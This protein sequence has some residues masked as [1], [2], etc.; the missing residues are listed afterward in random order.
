[1]DEW[2]DYYQI[3]GVN[4]DATAD[5]IKRAYRDKS[6]ILHPDRLNGTPASAKDRAQEELKRVNRAYDILGDPKKRQ[7]YHAKWMR[8]RARPRPTGERG[9][10]SAPSTNKAAAGDVSRVKTVALWHRYWSRA[11]RIRVLPRILLILGIAGL[12]AGLIPY[13]TNTVAVQ[14]EGIPIQINKATYYTSQG[15]WGTT[16][17]YSEIQVEPTQATEPNTSYLLVLDSGVVKQKYRMSW[18]QLELAIRKAKTATNKVSQD[19]YTALGMQQQ[20]A[21]SAFELRPQHQPLYLVPGL[22][23]L[24]GFILSY[25]RYRGSAGRNKGG[26]CK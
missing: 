25:M 13:F 11:D 22:V 3:L 14:I 10:N 23:I 20:Y 12:I 26:D 5:D 21:T 18:S 6:F 19:E 2:E 1:M 17:Y 4:P 9:A 16:N 8:R 15:F 7:E 24:T